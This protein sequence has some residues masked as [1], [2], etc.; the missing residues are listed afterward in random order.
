MSSEKITEELSLIEA[1]NGGILRPEDVVEFAKNPETA[2]HSEFEWDN[3]KAAYLHRVWKARY[4]IR[5]VVTYIEANEE[6]RPVNVYV[7]LTPDRERSG[8]GY[9]KLVT[10]LS[11]SEMRN[12]LLQDAMKE[13]EIFQQKYQNIKELYGIFIEIEKVRGRVPIKVPVKAKKR[14]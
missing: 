13:L 2:L 9:R 3:D 14:N 7:S 5:T 8:G 4:L 12:Q 10:V 1:K 11:N 6:K